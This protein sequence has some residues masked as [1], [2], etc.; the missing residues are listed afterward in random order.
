[1]AEN[2]IL[3]VDP[4]KGSLSLQPSLSG[5]QKPCCFSQLNAEFLSGSG[6][7]GYPA[8]GLDP[9]LLRGNPLFTEISLWNFSCHLWEPSQASYISSSL[10]TTVIV[11]KWCFL[12]LLG[13]KVSLQLVFSRLFRMISL[14]FSC[15][16]RLVLGGS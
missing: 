14:H 8:W 9:T 10:P 5:R 7:V 1:M 3:C 6:A 12:S 16:S 4:L 15:N 2:K 11:V 13:Y